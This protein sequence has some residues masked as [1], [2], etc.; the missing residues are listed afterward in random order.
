MTDLLSTQALS[1]LKTSTPSSSFSSIVTPSTL[2]HR[3]ISLPRATAGRTP[4]NIASV[5]YKNNKEIAL[6]PVPKVKKINLASVI[7]A[8]GITDPYTQMASVPEFACDGPYAVYD[9][10]EGPPVHV[11]AE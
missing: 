5:I 10:P 1:L 3:S 4:P 7:L 11:A 2:N 8:N 9:D 6:R